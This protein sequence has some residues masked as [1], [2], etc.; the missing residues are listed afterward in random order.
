MDLKTYKSRSII[1]AIAA[2]VTVAIIGIITFSLSPS[3]KIKKQLDLGQKYLS[4]LNYEQAIAAFSEALAIDPNSNDAIAGITKAYGDWSSDLVSKQD[5]ASAVSSLDEARTLLANMQELVDKEVDVY[6]TWIDYCIDKNDYQKAVDVANEGY[7][8]LGDERLLSKRDELQAT[9]DSAT[10]NQVIV[11]EWNTPIKVKATLVDYG[12][13]AKKIWV[14]SGLLGGAGWNPR[15]LVFSEP[16]EFWVK[17]G[18]EFTGEKVVLSEAMTLYGQEYYDKIFGVLGDDGLHS[19]LY[20]N[21]EIEMYVYP[22]A[23]L[24]DYY[25]GEKICFQY[26]DEE[27]NAHYGVYPLGGY[28]VIIA[29]DETKALNGD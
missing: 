3:Q 2:L 29:E 6:L 18:N 22:T 11:D 26:N 19:G 24:D 8:K 17:R 5:Y 27:G 16:Y 13:E 21:Q 12:D 4:E 15:C 20:L 1:F 10:E 9:I 25:T 14:D 23:F 28:S 7:N